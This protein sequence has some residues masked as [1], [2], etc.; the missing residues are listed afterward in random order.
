MFLP[1]EVI[2]VPVLELDHFC[3][4]FLPGVPLS[5]DMLYLLMAI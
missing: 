1:G 3:R 4:R 5:P 2:L